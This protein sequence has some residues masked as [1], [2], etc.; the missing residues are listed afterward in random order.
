MDIHWHARF[1]QQAGWTRELRAYLY[2]KTG[3]NDAG[4]VLE[5]G[6]G[7]GA[8]L[9]DMTTRSDLRI[10]GLDIDPTRLA[11]ARTYTSALFTCG[12]AQALPYPDY[13]FNITFCHYLLLWVKDPV[14]VLAE[15]KRATKPGGSVL[16]MAEPDYSQRVD[17]PDSLA[18]LGK[19]QTEALRKQGANPEIGSKLGTLFEQ[20]GI[21]LIETGP[22]HGQGTSPFTPGER[23]LEWRVLEADLAGMVPDQDIRKMKMLDEQAWLSGTRVLLIP[24][25]YAWGKA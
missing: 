6:C 1:L 18:I 2:R 7:T 13:S 19:W 16:V 3:L 25:Y 4:C 21:E 15:M 24:T 8:I 20:A 10:H 14:Q 12:D 5:V 11:E 22:L 23:E 9:I 17:K